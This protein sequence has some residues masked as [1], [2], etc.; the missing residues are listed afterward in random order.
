[1][2]D[3]SKTTT[4]TAAIDAA[5]T[6]QAEETHQEINNENNN[7][8]SIINNKCSKNDAEKSLLK[9]QSSTQSNVPSL[10]KQKQHRFS[11]TKLDDHN[12]TICSSVGAI[13][14]DLNFD[15]SLSNCSGSQLQCSQ[16]SAGGAQYNQHQYHH[17]HHHQHQEEATSVGQ[18]AN[19]SNMSQSCTLDQMLAS[20]N[21]TLTMEN[22]AEEEQQANNIKLNNLSNF[23]IN[24]ATKVAASL[25]KSTN[26][27]NKHQ[28][29]NSYQHNASSKTVAKATTTTTAATTT[30]SITKATIA[31][32]GEP[33]KQSSF[34]NLHSNLAQQQQQQADKRP[35]KKRENW[36]KNIEFL[37]AVIGFAVDLGNVWRFPY[38]CY[39]NGGGA[40]LIP[41]TIMFVVGG[42]PTFYLEM[43]L[44]Q[45]FSSG[46]LTVWR[47]VCPLAKGIGYAMC[48]LNFYTGLFY[49]TIIS[50]A[51]F[52][53]VK[54][55]ASEL[56][57][58]SCNNPWNTVDCRTIEQR[59]S[60]LVTLGANNSD[61]NLTS[62]TKEYFE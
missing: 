6:V 9:R 47:R 36:D 13:T 57:W 16:P 4:T 31:P 58:T 28:T 61:A 42:L 33:S 30:T 52:F 41:Y 22:L 49:N 40:F 56:P 29:I 17:H 1:M 2:E 55:F 11:S 19:Q 54:S 48:L 60:A 15:S 20:G 3:L 46:C 25:E 5:A 35:L 24:V 14:S 45:Y 62:P 34:I 50:W 38:V 10:Q 27:T 8:S 7:S 23:P 12:S 26:S 37:L 32:D 39:K 18:Q 43:S 53:C 21:E 59:Q 44:G 51:V